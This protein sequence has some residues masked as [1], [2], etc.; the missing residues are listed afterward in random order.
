MAFDEP[1]AQ[2]I[3]AA[4]GPTENIEEKR[5]MGALVFMVN[6]HMC[7]G[8]TGE[9]LMVRLGPEAGATALQEKHVKPLDIGAGRAPRAFVCVEPKGFAS[10]AAL[11][12]WLARAQEFV[13][14]LPPK[15]PGAKKRPAQRS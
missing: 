1:T 7:C 5:M 11:K 3:R 4:L 2:H 15:K 13:A 8:V 12:K 14:T 10:A 9:D 6:G